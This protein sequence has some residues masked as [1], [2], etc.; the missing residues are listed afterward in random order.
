MKREE[1]REREG[2][3]E[4]WRWKNKTK[5]Q[6]EFDCRREL[7]LSRESLSAAIMA[8]LLAKSSSQVPHSGNFLFFVVAV[9]IAQFRPVFFYADVATC[10]ET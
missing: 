5:N 9:F 10:S 6:V 3:R 2:E 1:E 8:P 7:G 4:I